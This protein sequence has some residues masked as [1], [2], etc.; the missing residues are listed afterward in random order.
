MFKAPI[1][2]SLTQAQ[3]SELRT[4]WAS[5]RAKLKPSEY[6]FIKVKLG[7]PEA[8]LT[9][10]QAYRLMMSLAELGVE[11]IPEWLIAFFDPQPQEVK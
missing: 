1:L 2:H 9:A 7:R 8:K 4:I 11:P 3:T 6:L 5:Q 10:N